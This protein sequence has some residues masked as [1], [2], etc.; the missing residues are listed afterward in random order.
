M[1][2][3]E[4]GALVLPTGRVVACDPQVDLT[5][6]PLETRVDPGEYPAFLA[7]AQSDVALV[8]IQF[9][10]G[11]PDRWVASSE[12]CGVDSATACLMDAKLCRMLLRQAEAGKW[13]RSWK[14]IEDSMAENNG[15]WANICLHQAS[16]ANMLVFRTYGGD[17]RFATYWGY[18]AKGKLIC[19]ITDMFLE[20]GVEEI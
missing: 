1:E 13:E 3:R 4:A 5:A 8:M 9:N 18:S 17:G 11:R 6:I 19:S 2:C 7:L 14:R 15:S 10:E 20:N 16:G 12:R